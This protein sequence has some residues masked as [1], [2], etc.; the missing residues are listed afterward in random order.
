MDVLEGRAAY[1]WESIFLKKGTAI[2]RYVVDQKKQRS[3]RKEKI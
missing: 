1:R 3:K 2:G